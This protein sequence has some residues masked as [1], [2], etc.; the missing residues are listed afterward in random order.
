MLLISKHLKNYLIS[1]GFVLAQLDCAIQ[2][3]GTGL[4]GQ[5]AVSQ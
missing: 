3:K 4:S 2:K 5:E 1:L